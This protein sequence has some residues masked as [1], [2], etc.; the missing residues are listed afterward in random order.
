MRF[1][2][3]LLSCISSLLFAGEVRWLSPTRPAMCLNGNWQFMGQKGEFRLPDGKWDKVPI[4]IPSPWNVNSFSRGPGGDFQLYPSYPT[5]WEEYHIGW[6]RRTFSV[7]PIMEGMRLFIRFEAVH[8]YCEVYV[9]GQKVGYHEGGFTPFEFDITDFVKKGENEL[10]VGVKDRSFF[11]VDGLTPYPWGSFWGE[12]IRGIW[13]DVYL[14]AR[15]TAYIDDL[16]VQTSYR[17]RQL[18]VTLWVTNKSGETQNLD[19]GIS[20]FDKE[21]K[22]VPLAINPQSI[23]IRNGERR[24]LRFSISWDNPHLWSPEDPY[25]YTLIASLKNSRISDEQRLRFG[26]REFWIEGNSFYLNGRRIKLRGDAWHYMGIPYQTPEYARLWFKMAKET[27]L[28]HIRLHAQVYPSFYLDIADEE[29]ILI[30]DESAIWASGCNFLYNTDFWQRAQQHIREWVTRDRNHPSVIIWSVANEI[31][32]SFYVNPNNGAPSLDWV[33]EKI[34][35]L[36]KDIKSLD[37]TRPVSSDGDQD[38]GG[39]AE[40]YSL[41]Y[42]GPNPPNT[43][44]PITIGESGSMFYSTPPEVAP[45]GGESVYLDFSNRLKGVGE[46]LRELFPNYRRWA[47]QITPFNVV[48]YSLE[49]LPVSGKLTYEDLET[50]GVKPERWGAYCTTLNPNYDPTL[51]PYKP[52]TL[53][54]YIKELLQ[55][56]TFFPKERN[57][58]FWGGEKITRSFIV[59]ND[60]SEDSKL[61]LHCN[62]LQKGEKIFS[63]VIPLTLG[64]CENKEVPFSFTL[65]EVTNKEIIE[66]NI[67]LWKENNGWQKIKE[68]T[69]RLSVFPNSNQ[70]LTETFILGELSALQLS[71]KT[72]QEIKSLPPSSVL[73]ITRQ[74]SNQEVDELLKKVDEGCKV[75]V[76]KSSPTLLNKLKLTLKAYSTHRAFAPFAH[77]IL[78]GIEEDELSF[79]RGGKVSNGGYTPPIMGTIK[80]I[81]F[82]GSGDVCLLEVK[83]GKGTLILS[84]MDILNQVKEEPVALQLLLN[85]VKYLKALEEQNYIRVGLMVRPSSALA[86]MLSAL[87]INAQQIKERDLANYDVVIADGRNLPS[88]EF[89][90]EFFEKGGTLFLLSPVPDNEKT[91]NQLLPSPIKIIQYRDDVQLVRYGKEQLTEGLY[92][93]WL[94]WLERD[95]PRSI[96]NHYFEGPLK[97]L[98]TTPITDWRKW[99]WQGEN[100]KT[101]A[102]LKAELERSTQPPKCV[103]GEI[104]VSKGKLILCG[105]NI[106]PDYPK[107]LTILSVLFSNLGIEM[108]PEGMPE[109]YID[110]NGYIMNWLVLGP[111]EGKDNEEMMK[112]KFIEE[113]TVV[114]QRM[115]VSGGKTWLRVTG[116]PLNFKTLWDKSYATAYAAFYIYSPKSRDAYLLIGSDDSIVIWLDGKEIW[117]NPAVRPLIPDSDRVPIRLTEGWHRLLFKVTQLTGDWGLCVKIVDSEGN[118]LEDIRYSLLPPEGGLRPLRPLGWLA[119]AQPK[120]GEELAFDRDINTRWS[121]NKPMEPGMYYLL[122]LGQEEEISQL[123]LDSSPSPGDYPRGVKL[124]VSLDKTNWQVV[125]ELSAEEV[126]KNQYKGILGISFDKVRARYIRITQLGSNPFLF[127]SIHEIYIY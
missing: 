125:K 26:F 81:V 71:A 83:W 37:G 118:L 23:T 14:I 41:H 70:S 53:Y 18:K 40:I 127:W 84:E 58:S 100:V 54:P 101:A 68:E 89:L 39:R 98:L 56:I 114:P 119:E 20:I 64:A 120:G 73:I 79:W 82:C 113:E 104:D 67:S 35:E 99:C 29:G 76:L 72:I 95:R 109:L 102:I 93:D 111:F 52:N 7:P 57:I 86:R 16:F 126:E 75:L 36:V 92:L 15:P 124:E 63:Q 94:F 46:E 61:E 5:E 74:L 13:Q 4:R 112:E 115:T 49:P 55:P 22:E 28:N 59:F 8:Y 33:F 96:V 117:R 24:E 77:P 88:S 32:A 123:I 105:M 116:S 97:S 121:S 103:L 45:T 10:L 110:E 30:T 65:P 122:D 50:P 90:K 66:L 78:K 85:S 19:A 34:Y 27:G 60:V 108:K 69:Y 31:M 38:L 48:W 9:N 47:Q 11:N 43:T 80:P 1:I 12:H 17:N 87:G 42:P 91:L 62:V 51:P 25:L 106:L 44:K 21:G 2:V 107:S 3:A 6:H